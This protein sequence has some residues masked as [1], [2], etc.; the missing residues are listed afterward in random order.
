MIASRTRRR[1]RDT[2]TA[3]NPFSTQLAASTT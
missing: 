1:V 3:Y 2:A